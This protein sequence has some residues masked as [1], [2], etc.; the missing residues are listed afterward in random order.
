MTDVRG[1]YVNGVHNVFSN[2]YESPIETNHGTWRT[3]E[4][5]FQAMKS[6][7]PRVWEVIRGL[8]R[9]GRAKAIGRLTTLRDGWDDVKEQVMAYALGV[10][11]AAGTKLAQV[12]LDTGD[13]YLEELNGWHD[14]YWGVC[15]CSEHAG[16]GKNRL[17]FLLMEQR[18][19]LRACASS[20]PSQTPP[21]AATT[22]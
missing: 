11:F 4:H 20:Q 17:G 5:Y 9:P 18:D 8:D 7:D 10:K 6:T 21:G 19:R 12:L 3:V 2:F 13:G 15:S 14:L 1:F 22:A 16:V